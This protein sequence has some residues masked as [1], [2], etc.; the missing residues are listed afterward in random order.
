MKRVTKSPRVAQPFFLQTVRAGGPGGGGGNHPC[1]VAFHPNVVGHGMHSNYP[2]FAMF[3]PDRVGGPGSALSAP[4]P[5]DLAL[6]PNG[7]GA[8]PAI[9]QTLQNPG[10][11]QER[12]R[13]IRARRRRLT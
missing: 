5:P 7:L 11:L 6:G 4:C 9:R 12:F 10:F 8:K 13:G 2:G 3:T 1:R